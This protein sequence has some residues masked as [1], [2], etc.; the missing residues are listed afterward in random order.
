MEEETP[1]TPGPGEGDNGHVNDEDELG[2]HVETEDGN[3]NIF[4]VDDENSILD[5]GSE[6][7]PGLGKCYLPRYFSRQEANFVFLSVL[8]PCRF[9]FTLIFC[10]CI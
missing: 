9:A 4:N 2:D 8:I 10:L 3:E 7:E 5:H 1:D 6:V